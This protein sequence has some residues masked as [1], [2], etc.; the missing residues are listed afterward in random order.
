[1]RTLAQV[2]GIIL[3]ILAFLQ[4]ITFDY[5]DVNPWTANILTPGIPAQL[6]NWLLVCML[7]AIGGIL[8]HFGRSGT[9]DNRK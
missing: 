8:F 7:G 5:P 9:R 1:M 6:L 3:M 4:W 2:A